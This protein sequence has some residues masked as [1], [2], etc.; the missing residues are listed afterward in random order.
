MN[1][2]IPLAGAGMRFRSAGYS[3][4]KPLID[5]AG[6]PMLYWALDSLLPLF[7]NHSFIFVALRE[8]FEQ[9]ELKDVIKSRCPRAI[10][11]PLDA[12]TRGQAETVWMARSFLAPSEPLLIFNGDT[13]VGTRIKETIAKCA[14]TIDGLINIFPSSDP[15]FSYVEI[16][17]DEL[18]RSVRE[19]RVIS[20]WATSGLYYFRST[21]GYLDMMSQA[22]I[23]PVPQEGEWYVALLYERMISQGS[24]IGVDH[25]SFCYPLGT[26]EQLMAFMKLS[27]QKECLY[28]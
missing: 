7:E 24:L 3:M 27:I 13:Y 1:I 17:S 2:V 8:V 28:E 25:A 9:T 21:R 10:L 16:D 12:P 15:A 4:P 14:E 18:V 20:T 11:V 23:D 26:P 6:R 5:V 19:K 22:L